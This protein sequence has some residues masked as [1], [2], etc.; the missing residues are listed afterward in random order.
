MH[1][2]RII[3]LFTKTSLNLQHC[4]SLHS[5]IPITISHPIPLYALYY[6]LPE[7]VMV[8]TIIATHRLPSKSTSRL[9]QN[10]L[11]V[12][13]RFLVFLEVGWLEVGLAAVQSLCLTR[14]NFS[15]MS[16]WK[17]LITRIWFMKPSK[18]LDEEREFSLFFQ[19]SVAPAIEHIT[20][21]YAGKVLH[22]QLK[23]SL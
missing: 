13:P 3:E 18:V 10:Q 19:E 8:K 15:T 22:F 4:W 14:C 9:W 16:I 12:F 2:P 5:K 21:K 6:Y 11:L 7:L 1:I 20:S 23:L 17:F